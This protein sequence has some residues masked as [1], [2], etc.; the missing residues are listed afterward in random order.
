MARYR[1]MVHFRH[2]RIPL[3]ILLAGTKHI[4]KSTLAT[5]L[6]EQLNLSVVLQ[7]DVVYDLM[8]DVVGFGG[9]PSWNR[10]HASEDELRRDYKRECG[11]VRKVR[12]L[13]LPLPLP[14]PLR[15]LSAFPRSAGP[16]ASAHSC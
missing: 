8:C 4:G 6:A 3:V 12:C 1:M 13:P 2:R 5:K 10:R 11:I 7:T 9:E 15:P 14:L 16:L